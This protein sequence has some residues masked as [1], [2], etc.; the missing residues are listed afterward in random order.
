M[1]IPFILGAIAIGSAAAGVGAGVKGLM[2]NSEANDINSLANSTIDTAKD[3]LDKARQA[4]YYSLEALGREKI[5]VFD[6]SIKRFIEAFEKL[7]NVDI[8]DSVGIN[9]INK[10][11]FD[12]AYFE[13]LKE[14]S[15]QVT[16]MLAGGIGG[17]GAGAL[18]AF[19]AYS[20][21]MTFAAASTGT[22][23]ASLSGVA[24]TNATLAFLGG[25]SL[26][27]GGFGMA[28][29]MAVLGGLVAG[30][31]LAIMGFVTLGASSKK[32]DDAYSNLAEANKISE[33]LET[34]RVSTNFIRRRTQMFER[35]LIRVDSLYSEAID[36]LEEVIN[37]QGTN[38][39]SYS[40]EAKKVVASNI[41][42]TQTIKAIL[43]TP[44]LTDNGS[45][46]E[47]S[48]KLLENCK[49]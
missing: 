8:S 25:G 10:L 48:T 31:A 37:Q 39:S 26:A 44:I 27:A 23:I 41:K 47:E 9:E 14:C 35:L 30:P 12:K 7:K 40:E 33:E 34:L 49:L 1:P 5:Y 42:L 2:N 4:T 16:S 36:N 18:A 15:L 22:A 29:G 45:I 20:A 21:T 46:S 28:G 11:K 43:D 6:V 38:Y 32:L 19:G 13:E 3:N 17:V 24:A